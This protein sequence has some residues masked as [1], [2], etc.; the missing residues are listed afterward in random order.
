MLKRIQVSGE[1]I[2]FGEVYN[3]IVATM[4]TANRLHFR[5][6]ALNFAQHRNGEVFQGEL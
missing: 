2:A 5:R 6:L 3:A 1:S 4:N